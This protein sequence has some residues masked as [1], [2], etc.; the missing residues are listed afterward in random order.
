MGL[1]RMKFI[2]SITSINKIKIIVNISWAQTVLSIS[3]KSFTW[4]K[5][6]NLDS[7]TV[8]E[9]YYHY[10]YFQS[11]EMFGIERLSNYPKISYPVNDEIAVHL[12]YKD[13]ST[14]LHFPFSSYLKS[15]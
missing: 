10:L 4:I 13:S 7:S 5:W 2:Y 9:K 15:N 12:I 14:H 6:F 3:Q 1:A 11:E 8:R